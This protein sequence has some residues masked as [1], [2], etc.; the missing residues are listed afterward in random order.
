MSFFGKKLELTF[1]VAILFAMN[2]IPI[3]GVYFFSW[4]VGT[5]LLLY[6]LETVIVGLFNIPKMLSCQGVAENSKSK[7][8]LGG[9]L[10]LCAFFT[11]H[12]GGFSFGHYAF[13]GS[14]FDAV[15]PLFE[16]GKTLFSATGLLFAT[17]GL[18]VSHLISMGINFYGKQEYKTRSPDTQ[19]FIPY[20]RIV[21]M[22]VVIIIGGALV[23]SF[24]APVLALIL[25]V[26]LK[27][28]IDLFAHGAEHQNLLQKP[29]PAMAKP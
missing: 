20:G 4:D 13:L 10:F 8:G 27:I 28:G 18:L 21:I 9:K 29:D 15:P 12:F 17:L 26:V 1:S 24:G 19:M 16:L 7:M 5:L 2:L 23:Q 22:H 6:W 11:V 3:A 25:L 14:F